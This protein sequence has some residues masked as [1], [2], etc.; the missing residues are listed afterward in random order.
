MTVTGTTVPDEVRA[1]RAVSVARAYRFELLKQ[2]AQWRVRVLVGLCWIGPA[3][4]V[5]VVSRQST[6]PADTLFGREM[7]ATGWAGALVV[8]SFAGSWFFPL[9]TSVVA[10]D[11]FS[12]EDRLGTW[13]HVLVAVRST[14]RIFICRPRY[15]WRCPASRFSPGT[16]CSPA[17]RSSAR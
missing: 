8:L 17:R 4:T 6:L 13:R 1:P 2:L 12:S 9:L 16:A 7:Q 15:A 3:I 10:G 5:V 14:R 11:V